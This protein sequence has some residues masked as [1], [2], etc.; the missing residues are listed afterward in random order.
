MK[1]NILPIQTQ[2]DIPVLAIDNSGKSEFDTCPFRGFIKQSLRLIPTTEDEHAINFGSGVHKGLETYYLTQDLQ[3]AIQETYAYFEAS[4][5]VNIT[6]HRTPDRAVEL[7]RQHVEKYKYVDVTPAEVTGVNGTTALGVEIPFQKKLGEVTLQA[8]VLGFDREYLAGEVIQIHW[9]GMIDIIYKE[10]GRIAGIMDHKTTG[11]FYNFFSRYQE[12]G[13]FKGY[14]WAVNEILAEM[15][16]SHDFVDKFTINGLMLSKAGKM[17]LDRHTFRTTRE[18][19]QQWKEVTLEDV[20]GIVSMAEKGIWGRS[21]WKNCGFMY[22]RPCCYKDV[23]SSN[24]ASY[25]VLLGSSAYKSYTW[26]PLN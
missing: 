21:G 14:L 25:G 10:N 12:S 22:G 5:Q 4:P 17:D 15:D 8:P 3:Q 13:Q 23:C 9:T 2:Q 7:I 16:L 24:Q 11:S 1:Q 6:D 26:N 20:K 19:L 18:K